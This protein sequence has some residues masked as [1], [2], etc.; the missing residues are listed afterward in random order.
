LFP[1]G[2]KVFDGFDSERKKAS[3][4]SEPTP[5]QAVEEMRFMGRIGVGASKSPMALGIHR[6]DALHLDKYIT[7]LLSF[8][9]LTQ[10]GGHGPKHSVGTPPLHRPLGPPDGLTVVAKMIMRQCNEADEK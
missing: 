7:S 9:K 5:V 6:L 3:L 1:S 4:L 8:A 2:L 10:G